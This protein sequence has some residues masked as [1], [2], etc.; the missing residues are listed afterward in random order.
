MLQA[1]AKTQILGVKEIQS[2]AVTSKK[3]TFSQQL[4]KT[5]TLHKKTLETGSQV[6]Q[7]QSFACG[8]R[9]GKSSARC[10]VVRSLQEVLTMPRSAL[11]SLL[12]LLSRYGA[13]RLAPL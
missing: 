10:E 3:V 5:Q 2:S 8:R 7:M 1:C 4:K 9:V 6:K 12:L 11:T 13:R